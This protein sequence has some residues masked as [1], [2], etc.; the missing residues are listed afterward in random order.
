MKKLLAA[1]ILLTTAHCMAQDVVAI[2]D[3]I[4]KVQAVTKVTLLPTCTV[5]VSQHKAAWRFC[6]DG[7][8]LQVMPFFSGGVTTSQKKIVECPTLDDAR[9]QIKLLGL[10]LTKEQATE[11]AELKEVPTEWSDEEPKEPIA[12]KPTSADGQ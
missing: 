9:T 6:H 8:V 7:K 5:Y 3:R 12:E 2:A 4:D 10:K 11:L 1:T